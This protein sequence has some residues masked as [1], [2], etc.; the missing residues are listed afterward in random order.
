MQCRGVSGYRSICVGVML[1]EG[2]G[3]PRSLRLLAMT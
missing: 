2:A 3:L 1:E